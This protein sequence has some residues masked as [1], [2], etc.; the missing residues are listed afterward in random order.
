[1]GVIFQPHYFLPI[2]ANPRLWLDGSFSNEEIIYLDI[3]ILGLKVSKTA[4]TSSK[5]RSSI[6]CST[7]PI[8]FTE[9]VAA[10]HEHISNNSDISNGDH[11]ANIFFETFQST[12]GY[13]A[14]C[15]HR[16]DQMKMFQEHEEL[17]GKTQFS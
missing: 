6:F 10:L 3:L 9:V 1:M 8:H 17:I 2:N 7:T 14:A 15:L 12:M 16:P 4:S 11:R 13:D 5:M